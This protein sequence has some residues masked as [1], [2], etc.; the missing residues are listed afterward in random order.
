MFLAT[1]SKHRV[2]NLERCCTERFWV[3]H[4]LPCSFAVIAV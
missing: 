4:V 2:G 1:F 3:Q